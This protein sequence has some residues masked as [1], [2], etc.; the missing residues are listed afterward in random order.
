M[1]LSVSYISVNLASMD[2]IKMDGMYLRKVTFVVTTLGLCHY[3]LINTVY[4][5]FIELHCV[6]YYR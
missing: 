6:R 5:P 4:Q 1:A 2:L 3:S